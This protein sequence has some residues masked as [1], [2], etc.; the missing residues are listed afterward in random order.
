MKSFDNYIRKPELLAPAGSPE[1]LSAAIEGGADAVYF[2]G[3]LFSNRMRAKNFSPDELL[4]SIAMCKAYSVRS[5]ITI[6]TRLRDAELPEALA[7]AEE[8]YAAGADAFIVADAGLAAAIRLRLPDAELHASTQM[9]GVNSADAEALASLGFSRMVCP[10]ELS[11]EELRELIKRSPIEIEM[12]VHG[13]HCVSVSGQC[14]MS[15][16]MGGRSGNRGEC[17]QPCRLPYRISGCK[18]VSTHPLSLKDMCL[19]QSIPEIL[20]LKVSSL[21]IEGRLKSADYV[22][23][24]TRIWRTLLDERRS[25]T[26]DEIACLDGI[27]SRD[28]FTDGYF[29]NDFH[30][31]NGMRNESTVAT[32]EKFMGLT[33]KIPLSAHAEV[34]LGK[35]CSLSL[36]CAGTTVSVTGETV[37]EAKSAPVSEDMLYRNIS[38][39]GGMPYSLAREDFT[40]VTDGKGFLT[41]SQINALR[42]SAVSLLEPAVAHAAK[43]ELPEAPTP[44]TP[45]KS[46][47]A[48]IRTAF[49]SSPSG[50]PESAADTFDVIFLPYKYVSSPET[51]KRA[52]IGISL[53]LWQTDSGTDQIKSAL[54]RFADA[55]GRYVLAH[56]YS[57]IKLSKEAGLIPIASER[58]NITN[59]G[60]A[61]VMGELGAQYVILS[62][63]LKAPAIRD[64]AKK[65]PVP[66]GCI[67]YGKL[68]LMLL[69]RCILS[70]SNCSGK[71]GGA[72]CLL[73]REISDRKGARLSVIPL[74]SRMNLILNPNPLW[75]AD[76]N[77]LGEMGITHF[78][79]TTE[80]AAEVAAVI[81]A[82]ARRLT[83]EQAGIPQIKRI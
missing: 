13:A 42:R 50:V 23:G 28:G 80:S 69:R 43:R 1:A 10:R 41:V 37:P 32:G 22:Y 26:P 56:S 76:K 11:Y 68:P 63:E 59:K 82:Y 57:Q 20:S 40:C 72:G 51:G 44:H 27:F 71:C 39:L 4:R 65:A 25:A 18:N 19:A 33:K 35:P 62:P 70:D 45:V 74:G 16:A 36:T 77:D 24:V 49:F 7:L 47:S 17:A 3:S 75:C 38:K 46:V 6:N 64:V 8:L 54:R 21:K 15:W 60:A 48:P 34:I 55:K 73:P 53:P 83:P 58:L 31:M 2:G 52:E 78:M 12:F 66:C 14:L 67:V 30:S 9:T 5:Y 79:F 81:D 61:E 29:T